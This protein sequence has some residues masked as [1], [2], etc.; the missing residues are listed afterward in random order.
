MFH[1]RQVSKQMNPLILNKSRPQH[2]TRLEGSLDRQLLNQI[3]ER[4]K[5][6]QER[7]AA[8]PNGSVPPGDELWALVYEDIPALLRKLQVTAT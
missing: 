7:L 4:C 3:S 2:R 1:S 8:N 5:A 6:A